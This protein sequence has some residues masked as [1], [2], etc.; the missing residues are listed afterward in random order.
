MTL[1]WNYTYA[2]AANGISNYAFPVIYNGVVYFQANATLFALNESTG[3]KIW[4]YGLPTTVKSSPT[5]S[6][7]DIYIGV[8]NFILV[9]DKNGAMKKVYIVCATCNCEATTAPVIDGDSIYIG[10][11]NNVYAINKTSGSTRWSKTIT[12]VQ[13]Q[14]TVTDNVYVRST[15]YGGANYVTAI[16]K[17]TGATAWQQSADSVASMLLSD[18]GKLYVIA[19]SKMK[20]FNQTSG[21]QITELSGCYNHK[22]YQTFAM[23]N[24]IIFDGCFYDGKMY[25]INKTSGSTIWSKTYTGNPGAPAVSNNSLL[26]F[27][28]VFQYNIYNITLVNASTGDILWT[29]RINGSVGSG[30]ALANDKLFIASDDGKF[31]AF[32]Y[33]PTGNRAPIFSGI[34]PNQTWPVNN[35]LTNITLNDYF[36]DPDSDPLTYTYVFE[37][38]NESDTLF[39]S[40]FENTMVADYALGN[41]TPLAVT[42]VNYKTGKFNQGVNITPTTNI[43]Y[44]ATNNFNKTIGTVEM[45]VKPNW[46]GTV[47]AIKTFFGTSVVAGANDWISVWYYGTFNNM[48]YCQWRGQ[49]AGVSASYLITSW[50]AGEWHHIACSWNMTGGAGAGI[51]RLYTDGVLRSQVVTAKPFN[52]TFEPTWFGLGQD[53]GMSGRLDG[54]MDDFKISNTIK[55]PD[56]N[57]TRAMAVTIN[58]ASD[59]TFIPS[60]DFT[61]ER[62]IKFTARDPGNLTADSNIV[63]LTVTP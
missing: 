10:T 29:Y 16:D 17:N 22:W 23:Q 62:K 53:Y 25:A 9:I 14:I 59:V 24:D 28:T 47:A 52:D 58:G 5:V 56:Y 32:N 38:A 2:G 34:I 20:V 33:T 54:V 21:Q 18:Q 51:L 50:K 6:G 7:G 41:P 19:N 13:S 26:V 37:A 48:L 27:G 44:N 4:A 39:L 63:T 1:A 57:T 60:T 12:G 35:N 3:A 40:R 8:F 31:Y 46:D 30:P 15:N 36:S 43:M 42:N 55:T 49:G 45:W 61:G 11:T